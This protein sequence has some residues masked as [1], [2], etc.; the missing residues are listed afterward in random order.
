M[1][2]MLEATGI[3]GQNNIQLLVSKK[4]I[5]EE[6]ENNDHGKKLEENIRQESTTKPQFRITSS[7]EHKT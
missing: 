2:N 1:E 6:N 7:H 5:K 4:E 3:E